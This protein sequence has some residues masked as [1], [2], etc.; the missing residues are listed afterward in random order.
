MIF[1]HSLNCI[2]HD[3]STILK[4]CRM[5]I[6]DLSGW[7]FRTERTRYCEKRVLIPLSV[8]I[9]ISLFPDNG[10]KFF[11]RFG[12]VEIGSVKR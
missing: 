4:P 7:R 10:E 5:G 3:H 8:G 12:R 2:Q 9:F 6:Y 11:V 1:L